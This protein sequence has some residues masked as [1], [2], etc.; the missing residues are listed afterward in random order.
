MAQILVV[1]AEVSNLP[2]VG[3]DLG[4]VVRTFTRGEC[5]CSA[6]GDAEFPHLAVEG[7]LL[8]I[9]PIDS[10]EN[11]LAVGAPCQVA[12]RQGSRPA[13]LELARRNLLRG[14]ALGRND[15]DLL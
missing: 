7:I 11:R 8:D 12:R 10:E 15:K 13:M 1:K 3:R 6:I 4:R 14:A 2:S 9:S 5:A